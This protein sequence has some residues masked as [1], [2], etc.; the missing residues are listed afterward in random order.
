MPF[1]TTWY[2][3]F[4]KN[5]DPWEVVLTKEKAEQ[6]IKR[7]TPKFRESTPFQLGKFVQAKNKD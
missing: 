3:I 4:N 5:G 1:P 2:I 7:D 6:V